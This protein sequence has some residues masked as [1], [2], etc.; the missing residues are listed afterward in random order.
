[1]TSVNSGH[2]TGDLNFSIDVGNLGV[3]EDSDSVLI[4]SGPFRQEVHVRLVVTDTPLPATGVEA[5]N[6][7]KEP[8]PPAHLQVE[9]TTPLEFEYQEGGTRPG[10]K[11]V[12]I[13]TADEKQGWFVRKADAWVVTPSPASGKGNAPR[14]LIS[15]DPSGLSPG[16]HRSSLTVT[17]EGLEKKLG[18]VLHIAP[19]PQG[20]K[21]GPP[22]PPPPVSCAVEDGYRGRLS[23]TLRWTGDLPANGKVTIYRQ[24][25]GNMSSSIASSG[26]P[27]GDPLPGCEVDV[28]P[29]TLGISISEKPQAANNFGM[30]TVHNE[31][32]NSIGS[33]Q[34]KWDV[35]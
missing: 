34:V 20:S 23:S 18:I 8:T 6:H 24:V 26:D 4:A 14:F 30:V 28:K 12:R 29:V 16:Y 27:K 17:S 10:A 22:K 19:A 7:P 35:K 32:Q 15:V 25:V 11:P 33:F 31:T 21:P 9:P 5:T 2:G 3:A 13:G 1:V